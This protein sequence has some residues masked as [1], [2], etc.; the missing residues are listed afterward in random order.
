MRPTCDI[1][2]DLKDG[3][4]VPYEELKAAALVQDS[5]I[6]FFKHDTQKL[7]KGGTEAD[8]IKRRNY[9]DQKTS[10]EK[11]GIPSW[12]WIAINKNP[13]EWLPPSLVEQVTKKK[14]G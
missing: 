12:Y 10:S 9:S 2:E 1:I 5:I 7:L 14:E 11:L 13:L 3:I 6:Y 4:E 8:S